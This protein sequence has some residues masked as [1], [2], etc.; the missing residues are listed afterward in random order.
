MSETVSKSTM[1]VTRT[2]YLSIMEVYPSFILLI[3]DIVDGWSFLDTELKIDSLFANV[4][5]LDGVNVVLF[6]RLFDPNLIERLNFYLPFLWFN[7]KKWS[8]FLIF[9]IAFSV[10]FYINFWKLKYFTF[11]LTLHLSNFLVISL[12]KFSSFMIFWAIKIE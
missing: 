2:D 4:T 1:H 11:I 8:R 5:L 3:V 12:P 9:S 6:Y 7:N 10:G